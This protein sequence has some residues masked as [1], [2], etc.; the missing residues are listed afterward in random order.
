MTYE[1]DFDD[2]RFVARLLMMVALAVVWPPQQGDPPAGEHFRV[3]A[4]RL[5][6]IL[7]SRFLRGFADV[8]EEDLL[9]LRHHL[10]MLTQ[11]VERIRED[12]DD[13]RTLSDF[14][15]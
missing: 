9:A 14:I 6:E 13:V 12:W 8:P 4:G 2:S 1:P 15:D 10:G 5:D 11:I 7:E 3:Q